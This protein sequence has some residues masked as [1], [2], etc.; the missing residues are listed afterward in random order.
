MTQ[1][2]VTVRSEAIMI[3]QLASAVGKHIRKED[4][5]K[6]ENIRGAL[7]HCSTLMEAKM[8]IAL[9]LGS[10]DRKK[11]FSSLLCRFQPASS[12]QNE[13]Q[14][15]TNYDHTNLKQKEMFSFRK[16]SEDLSEAPLK[17]VSREEILGIKN[18]NRKDESFSNQKRRRIFD[19]KEF[20]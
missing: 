6:F 12:K 11:T 9:M 2:G 7:S 19:N 14:T 1:N 18:S 17:F 13:G 8:E 16:M 5:M 10:S 3:N 4:V 15:T 20:T